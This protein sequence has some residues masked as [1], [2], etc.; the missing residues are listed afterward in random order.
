MTEKKMY[1]ILVV[2]TNFSFSYATCLALLKL[3]LL[4]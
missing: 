2:I 1:F 3:S 4:F